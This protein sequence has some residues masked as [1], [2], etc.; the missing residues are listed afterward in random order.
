MAFLNLADMTMR[1]SPTDFKKNVSGWR[2]HRIYHNCCAST[3]SG[4]R[5]TADT[6]APLV[7]EAAPLWD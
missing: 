6:T 2:K 5:R 3:R 1:D 7:L 4:Q